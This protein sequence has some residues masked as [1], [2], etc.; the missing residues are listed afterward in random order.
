M[1]PTSVIVEF[2]SHITKLVSSCMPK[3]YQI[4]RVKNSFY[5][6]TLLLNI[7]A[8]VISKLLYFS[9]VWANTS[10][11]N[12]KRLQ[13]IQ[14]FACKIV[15][16]TKKY[17]LLRLPYGQLNW[18]LLKK[19]STEIQSWLIS[20]WTT[21]SPAPIWVIN[22]SRDLSYMIVALAATTSLT[23]HYLG[24]PRG[25]EH[26]ITG[27]YVKIWNNLD[28]ELKNVQS[29]RFKKKLKA[30]LSDSYN[31]IEHA[32]HVTIWITWFYLSFFYI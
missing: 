4:N 17:D 23:Y 14:N 3:L 8:L 22:L 24:L 21:S 2:D 30:N 16:N 5:H 1:T 12:I 32:L 19:Q 11:K 26:F 9:T 15:T 13:A 29:L 31:E 28:S 27:L 20:V 25:R 6:K 10:D 18:L 7:S